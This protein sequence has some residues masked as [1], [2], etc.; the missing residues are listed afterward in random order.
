MFGVVALAGLMI[1]LPQITQAGTPSKF[2]VSDS[3]DFTLPAFNC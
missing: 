1:A 3:F 2:K